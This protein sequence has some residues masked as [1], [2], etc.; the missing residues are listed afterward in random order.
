MA[1]NYKLG[2]ECTLTISSNQLKLAKEVTVELGGSEADVTT[3]AS[4]GIKQSVLALKEVTIS[5]TALYSSDDSA[6]QALITA[7]N[8][9]TALEV[10]FSDPS[11]TYTGKWAVISLSNGQ[12]LED[13][14]TLDFTLK[15]TIEA[16]SGA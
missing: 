9:G 5:G 11:F 16:T 14:A 4:Q 10:T 6:V 12:P 8:N 2:R 13:V 15:P 3:R 1:A 7:Y